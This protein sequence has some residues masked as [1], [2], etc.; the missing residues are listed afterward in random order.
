MKT[1]I[2]IGSSTEG[3]KIANYVRNYFSKDFDCY[4]WNDGIFSHNESVLDILMKTASS[5]DFGIMIA[6]NDDYTKSRDKVFE[7]AR[8]NIIFEFG[9]FLGRLG[10]SRSFILKEEGI[11]LPSDLVGVSIPQFEVT[12]DLF[13][14]PLLN[15]NLDKIK[16]TIHKKI[17]LGE[18]GLLPSTALAIGYF[19][20]FI[21]LACET[22]M[23]EHIIELEGRKY[24]KFDLNII[25][26]KDLDADIKKRAT[27]YF[28]KNSLKQF[29]LKCSSR[30]F[31]IYVTYNEE[32]K[33]KLSL[34][35]M[36]TTLNGIDKSIELF[37]RKGHTGK[38]TEQ[39]LLEEMELRNFK[40]TLFNLVQNDAFCRDI[41]KFIDG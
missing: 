32:D 13:E 18:L 39:Q 15:K 4:I 35:D 7:T 16:Q 24:S 5:F 10:K 17:S 25:I 34:F 40:T 29:Q 6:T 26:P 19:Y 36:P 33:E 38:S 31:P 23:N 20:N 11:Q 14:A 21:Q 28:R 8:D 37:L 30:D 9:L 27:M 22:L 3:L 12:D 1:R 2:F 41:V